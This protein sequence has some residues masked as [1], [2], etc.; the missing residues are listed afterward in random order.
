M[1]TQC[2]NCNTIFTVTMEQIGAHHGLVRCGRC[3][4]V[5]NASW[6]LVDRLPPG[7][8]EASQ[9][10]AAGT[11]ASP[12][13]PTPIESNT[14]VPPATI[15]DQP[16]VPAPSH[17]HAEARSPEPGEAARPDHGI[18]MQSGGPGDAAEG[19][20]KPHERVVA[21]RSEV[22]WTEQS[23]VA[24]SAR[25][26]SEPPAAE[27]SPE[28]RAEAPDRESDMAPQ[29]KAR[30]GRGKRAAK[31]IVPGNM[32]A[33]DDVESDAA[34]EATAAERDEGLSAQVPAP[35]A[36]KLPPS[37]AVEMRSEYIGGNRK[38]E[39]DSRSRVDLAGADHARGSEL[40][41]VHDSNDEPP[42]NEIEKARFE[43]PDRQRTEPDLFGIDRAAAEDQ[44]GSD[45]EVEPH[46]ASAAR[47]WDQWEF[48]ITGDAGE[49]NTDWDLT[50]DDVSEHT[51]DPGAS[52][53]GAMA[54][55]GSVETS[56]PIPSSLLWRDAFEETAAEPRSPESLGDEADESVESTA[57]DEGD[58]FARL[59][60]EYG[61]V[62]ALGEESDESMAEESAELTD[63]DEADA[64]AALAAE[65]EPVET[66]GE[67]ADESVAEESAEATDTDEADAFA[68]LGAESEPVEAPGEE[69]DESV[70]EEPAESTDT[71]EADA[72]AALGA[73]SEPVETP[74]EEADE[75]AAEESAEATD[76]DEADAFA[77]L[78]AE[79]ES[80]GA[81]A[82][83]TQRWIGADDTE[84]EPPAD[85]GEARAESEAELAGLGTDTQVSPPV[86]DDERGA[87][88]QAGDRTDEGETSE[89][90]TRTVD[91]PEAPSPIEGLTEPPLAAF[92]DSEQSDQTGQDT[93]EEL[94]AT[95]AQT[96]TPVLDDRRGE[97]LDLD[98]ESRTE[99]AAAAAAAGDKTDATPLPD[100]EIVIEAPPSLWDAFD[101]SEFDDVKSKEQ[102]PSVYQP[103]RKIDAAEIDE[104]TMALGKLLDPKVRT[105]GS[106][107]A[108][109]HA[110]G[111]S[112][113]LAPR[114][115][116]AD[117]ASGWYGR[118]TGKFAGM[119]RSRGI[120]VA[121]WAITVAVL[122]ATAVWQ[123]QRFY[124]HELAQFDSVRPLLAGFCKLTG[125]EVPARSAPKL[126]DLMGTS[127]NPHPDSPGALRVT[128]NLINRADFAQ[129]Y[130]PLEVTLTD[131]SG[132]VIGRRTY[133]PSEY[134]RDAVAELSP[135]VVQ[136]VNI[137]LAEPSPEAVGYEIQL[138][139]R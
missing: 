129:A 104:M 21:R 36:S 120:R 42:V 93:A 53:S 88:A 121:L 91:Q 108:A 67:E 35:V 97:Q 5:F 27:K 119:L 24:T 107:D 72:F 8:E 125:C 103:N 137:D 135:N 10:V 128:I 26:T 123:V 63:T 30:A 59:A 78:G 94:D 25:P 1:Y 64:F 57:T 76:T 111:L 70:A 47:T 66:L 62:E 20:S 50:A 77:A 75:S 29:I 6:N 18:G 11:A 7:A 37:E 115:V 83:E 32:S 98:M 65:S 56:E 73:E 133:T 41:G 40:E 14:V 48:E 71:D 58:V 44:S 2:A 4:D 82:D 84:A 118:G 55:K 99:V 46:S 113:L 105:R 85:E 15:P 19:L 122:L 109:A 28:G 34:E 90:E 3:G 86:A 69:A 110:A 106:G 16:D 9:P 96:V 130:P 131:R 31:D 127:V 126:I 79:S 52:D 45:A 92:V 87:R 116:Y 22:V 49:R 17:A 60:A 38:V 100:E 61:P 138:V 13:T 136:Q 33:A 114:G 23:D 68:A 132:Q 43:E 81:E 80:V 124:L 117:G 12:A 89:D 54:S 74:G 95:S 101:E 134:E 112:T 139:N 102:K 51:A 39:R